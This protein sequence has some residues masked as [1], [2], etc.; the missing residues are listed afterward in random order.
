MRE[1]PSSKTERARALHASTLQVQDVCLGLQVH[2][3]KTC[4]L[5]RSLR[6]RASGERLALPEEA[7]GKV[8][9][10]TASECGW[11]PREWRPAVETR[12]KSQLSCKVTAELRI[13]EQKC[14]PK[15]WPGK[16]W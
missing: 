11:R 9:L 7:G 12:V 5:C 3:K 13:L 15:P 2:D 10:A 1:A 6:A 16:V 4:V 14:E 8:T